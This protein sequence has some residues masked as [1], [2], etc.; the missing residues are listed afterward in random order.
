[1]ALNHFIGDVFVTKLLG[2]EHLVV[3]SK[4][5][6]LKDDVQKT[7]DKPGYKMEIV[8]KNVA[9]FVVIHSLALYGLY[10][11]ISFRV[12]LITILFGKKPHNR[13]V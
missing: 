12:R 5:D 10:L 7:K 11:M 3:L 2:N 1:M 4:G 9:I 8:W 13:M 6:K